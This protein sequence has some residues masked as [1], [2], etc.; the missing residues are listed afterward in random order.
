VKLCTC[1]IHDPRV[2]KWAEERIHPDWLICG[3]ADEVIE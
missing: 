1:S 2:C 3:H